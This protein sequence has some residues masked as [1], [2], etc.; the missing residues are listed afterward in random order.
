MPSMIEENEDFIDS[1]FDDEEAR[2][3][4]KREKRLDLQ[5]YRFEY[6]VYASEYGNGTMDLQDQYRCNI[7]SEKADCEY[8]MGYFSIENVDDDE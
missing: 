7:Y 8:F 3:K 4:Y 6:Y 2:Q 5:R 1:V